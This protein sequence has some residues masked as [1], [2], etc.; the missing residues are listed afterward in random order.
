MVHF[1][2]YFDTFEISI[3]ENW[4]TK[5]VCLQF[6]VLKQFNFDDFQSDHPVVSNKCCILNSIMPSIVCQDSGTVGS[7]LSF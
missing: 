2:P 4:L 6:T 7:P 5:A 1:S 3:F